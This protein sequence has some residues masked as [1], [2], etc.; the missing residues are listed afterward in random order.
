MY[1]EKQNARNRNDLDEDENIIYFIDGDSMNLD[2]I[3][4]MLPVSKPEMMKAIRLQHMQYIDRHVFLHRLYVGLDRCF[5]TRSNLHNILNDFLPL[6]C[7]LMEKSMNQT[8]KENMKQAWLKA[9]K[10]SS[11]AAEDADVLKV[12]SFHW[13]RV[14]RI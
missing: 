10:E 8:T 9:M 6:L 12:P 3:E 7:T 14:Y 13:A 4:H 1:F 2:H 5:H 11:T